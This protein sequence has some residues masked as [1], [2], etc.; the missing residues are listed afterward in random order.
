MLQSENTNAS[1]V[2]F[3]ASW[4]VLLELKMELGEFSRFTKTSEEKG[5]IIHAEDAFWVLPISLIEKCETVIR[6]LNIEPDNASVEV[7]KYS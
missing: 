4:V 5:I 6:F 3:D 1:D 2:S 7:R